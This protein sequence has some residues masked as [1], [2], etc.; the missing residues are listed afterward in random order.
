MDL[1]LMSSEPVHFQD[2]KIAPREF[3]GMMLEKNLGFT[4][5]EVVLVLIEAE[6][7][8]GEAWIRR[9]T[10]VID[11]YDRANNISA[12]MRMTGYSAAIV[13]WML[14]AGEITMPGAHPQEL[15]LPAQRFISELERRG[16]QLQWSEEV[17]T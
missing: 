12:M 5:E 4:S 16:I 10:R 17:L 6:G 7:R 3:L 1:G 14:A 9:S 2:K 8:S 13:A 15:A 11:C